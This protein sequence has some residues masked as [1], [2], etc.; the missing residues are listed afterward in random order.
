MTYDP[1]NIFA[2][3]IRG[4]IPS[5]KVFEDENVL[6]ISDKFPQAPVHILILPK[7]PYID[8]ADFAKNA[9]DAEIVA[10]NRVTAF[11]ISEFNLEKNG[12]RVITN[13]GEHGGQEIPHLHWHVVGG[14][15][16]GKMLSNT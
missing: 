12:Y 13:S 7:N 16:L 11:V 15:P 5:D 3:I 4:E 10:L 1:D 14:H 2:K 6:V 9:S 8:M